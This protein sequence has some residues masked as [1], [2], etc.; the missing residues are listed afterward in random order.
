MVL[1]R[2]LAGFKGDGMPLFT[3]LCGFIRIELNDG[4][5]G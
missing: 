4:A 1:A 5:V 3:L 2:L